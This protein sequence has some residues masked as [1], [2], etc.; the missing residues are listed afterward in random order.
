VGAA[1]D[2]L[3]YSKAGGEIGG[4]GNGFNTEWLP[5]N[6]SAAT[7]VNIAAAITGTDG[8]SVVMN[9]RSA[10][11]AI[12]DSLT[13]NTGETT[14]TTVDLPAGTSRLEFVADGGNTNAADYAVTVA[15]IPT[16]ANTD[17]DGNAIAAG[18]NSQI[19]VSFPQSGLY[20][21]TYGVD[22][23]NGRYQ[24][25]VNNQFVQKTAE[26]DGS[27]AFYIPQGTHTLTIDQDSALGADWSLVLSGPGAAN[28]SLP[29]AKMGGEIGGGGNDFTQEWLPVHVGADTAVNAL[30]TIDGS[31]ADTV[32][33]EIW[34]AVTR[35]ETINAVHGTESVWA[36][37]TLPANGRI[38]MLAQGN[39]APISYEVEII[40]IPSPSFSWQGTSLAGTL[41]STIHLNMQVGG[42]YTIQGDYPQGFAS[43]IIDPPAVG[44]RGVQSDLEM[45]VEL[46]AGVH[47]FV[48]L[49]GDSFPTSSFIYTVTLLSA[50]APEITSVT[51]AQVVSG[52]QT[53]ITIDGANFLDGAV[54]TLLG[55]NDYTLATTYVSGSQLTAVVPAT[56]DLGLYTVQVTNPD[57]QSAS[58]EVDIYLPGSVHQSSSIN[59][60]YLPLVVKNVIRQI[61]Q[62]A[63]GLRHTEHRIQGL[64]YQ[65]VTFEVT[66]ILL[67]SRL[68]QIIRVTAQKFRQHAVAQFHNTIHH[69]I[70]KVAVVGNHQH[71]A[72]KLIQGLFQ[73]F[74]GSDVQVVGWFVQDEQVGL[75][76]HQLCQLQAA[77]FAAAQV[78]DGLL[79]LIVGKQ[80]TAQK[81]NG[82]FLAHR[83]RHSHSLNQCLVVVQRLLFLG[84]IANFAAWP[85]LHLSG[86]DGFR[87]QQQ[88]KQHRL[89]RPVWPHQPHALAM[90][91]RH[92][93]TVI[94]RIA[95][96]KHL[97]HIDQ[98]DCLFAAA[99]AVQCQRHA[100]RL[101][102]LFNLVHFVQHLLPGT[103]LTDV[104]LIHHQGS[105]Q[106]KALDGRFDAGN[107]FLLRGV[108]LLLAQAAHGSL[109]GVGGV[110]AGVEG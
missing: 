82:R 49:Q 79:H 50:Y 40:D 76:Q 1:H 52:Q 4:A 98:F 30:V 85:N 95:V 26:A 41:N 2:A 87:F 33:L 46:T 78:G 62:R 24:F 107:F 17:W 65:T 28:D 47:T 23:G 83:R 57:D 92:I 55:D 74:N 84:V 103:R 51:P 9:V 58:L 67:L 5:L 80:E 56:V 96:V 72:D 6:L 21:F 54:V 45:T 63:F 20:T 102:H 16:A 77:A 86:A 38:H 31:T 100:P 106:F 12:L 42:F 93:Q 104:A 34:D 109:G 39:S 7:A 101:R 108:Q 89:A 15:A 69:L 66:V 18:E 35:T 8:D 81:G 22:S 94:E 13:V 44:G 60:L 43:L 48:T 59:P 36:A 88:L 61:F 37:F 110:V 70:Q 99:P 91:H 29:Y 97:F 3:P 10:S 75:F 19:R 14:W 105:P 64:P 32:V 27:V 71:R 53:T 25:L 11:N 68:R 73:H 90:P